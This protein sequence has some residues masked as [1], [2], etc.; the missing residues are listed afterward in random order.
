MLEVND[1]QCMMPAVN[2]SVLGSTTVQPGASRLRSFKEFG[3]I[4]IHHPKLAGVKEAVL[5]AVLSERLADFCIGAA[6]LLD[7]W[8]IFREK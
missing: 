2:Q 4:S 7:L 6:S 5:E 3:E 1:N 8:R